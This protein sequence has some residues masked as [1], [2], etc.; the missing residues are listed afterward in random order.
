MSCFELIINCYKA[1]YSRVTGNHGL[2]IESELMHKKEDCVQKCP[3]M[4][5]EELIFIECTR[6]EKR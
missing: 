1:I 6:V 2:S 5:A 3:R 4:R